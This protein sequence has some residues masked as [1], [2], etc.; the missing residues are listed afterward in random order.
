MLTLIIIVLFFLALGWAKGKVN[1]TRLGCLFGNH[2]WTMTR[3]FEG[4]PHHTAV[5][6]KCGISPKEYK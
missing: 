4:R 5:C 2:S 1:K 3:G 6:S